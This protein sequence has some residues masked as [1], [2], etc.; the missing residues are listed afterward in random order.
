MDR[1]LYP[2]EKRIEVTPDSAFSDRVRISYALADR[3][4]SP[5][6]PSCQVPCVSP[7]PAGGSPRDTRRSSRVLVTRGSKNGE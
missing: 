5:S 2:V 1:A 7:D 3:F 6:A 4:G